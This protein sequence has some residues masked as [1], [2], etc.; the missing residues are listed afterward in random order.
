MGF[1]LML[2]SLV[3]WA[4][5]ALAVVVIVK[6]TL[7]WLRQMKFEKMDNGLAAGLTGLFDLQGA[8]GLIFLIWAGLTGGGWPMYRIE[9]TVTMLVAVA[10]AHLPRIWKT[11]PDALRFRNTLFCFLGAF[12]LIFLGIASLPQGWFG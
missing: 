3:R 2:H 10:I 6:F 12:A 11:A 9:H 4:V 1:I 8:L 7:G 5:V